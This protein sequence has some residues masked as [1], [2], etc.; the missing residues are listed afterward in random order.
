MT[1]D[2]PNDSAEWRRRFLSEIPNALWPPGQ[3]VPRNLFASVNRY[4]YQWLR[5]RWRGVPLAR[6]EELHAS[7][8][9]VLRNRI[10]AFRVLQNTPR[11]STAM[12][13]RQAQNLPFATVDD[14]AF[15]EATQAGVQNPTRRGRARARAQY[16]REDIVV[17]P[18]QS[19]YTQAWRY[20]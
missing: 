5:A 8:M 7:A 19:R 20:R 13:F 1:R 16:I 14:V 10:E 17:L 15:M 2:Y 3:E 4:N 6:W 9:T 11:A 12:A 18:A